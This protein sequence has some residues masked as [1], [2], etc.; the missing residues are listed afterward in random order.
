MAPEELPK[1]VDYDCVRLVD[2]LDREIKT[3]GKTIWEKEGKIEASVAKIRQDRY[4]IKITD[5]STQRE[6]IVVV[7]GENPFYRKWVARSLG[8]DTTPGKIMLV[9]S[10]V[11][12]H[13]WQERKDLPLLYEE[14]LNNALNDAIGQDRY[15]EPPKIEE[16]SSVR[17]AIQEIFPQEGDKIYSPATNGR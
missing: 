13:K 2:H 17:R 15:G 7:R 6:S 16:F 1:N 3:G 11:E 8:I 14:N 9:K 4:I 12:G 5:D 10:R